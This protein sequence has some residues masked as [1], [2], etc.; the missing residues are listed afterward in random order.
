M[1]RKPIFKPDDLAQMKRFIEGAR[2]VGASEKPEDFEK[3]F[4]KVAVPKS[5]SPRSK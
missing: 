1:P 5:R 4:K 3:A 2:Q